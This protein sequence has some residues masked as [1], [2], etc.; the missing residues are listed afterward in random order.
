MTAGFTV[1]FVI[2]LADFWIEQSTFHRLEKTQ[3]LVGR[4][5]DA[6]IELL[7]LANAYVDAET[8]QR[9]Y[10]LTG[11]E[12]YL[13]PYVAA[14]SQLEK[15]A[16]GIRRV[17]TDDSELNAILQ[18]G[19]AKLAELART[20][21]LRRQ[22]R[23]DEALAIVRA[24]VGK[25]LMDQI[26][27]A[28]D[29][30][31]SRL[32]DTA[33]R[34]VA[35]MNR[36]RN[37]AGISAWVTK[38]VL[39]GALVMF[40]LVIRLI[41]KEREDALQAER[42]AKLATQQALASER[43]AHS[44]AAHANQL[45]DEFLG[46]VSHELRTPLSA[47]L[48]WT[49]LLREGAEDEDELQEGLAMIERNARAQSRLVEDLLDVSRIISGKVRL[50]IKEVNLR[51]VAEAV[52]EGLRPSAEAK[53]IRLEAEWTREPVEVL[54]DPDRLQQIG[55]NLVSNAIKFTPRNGRIWVRVARVD[56]CVEL[57]VEDTGRG[58]RPEFLPRIFDRFSQED[59]STTRQ[60]SGLGLGLA[61]A[62]HLVE[63]HGGTIS[64]ESAGEGCGTTFRVQI[65]IVAVREIRRQFDSRRPA[66][67]GPAARRERAPV[68]DVSGLRGLR[69]LA[70]DDQGDARAVY[71]RVLGRVG[72][73]VRTA[74]SVA[75]ALAILGEWK[76][77][78]IISDIGM[79]G[80][81]GYSFVRTLRSR[82]AN[83]GGNIPVLA[84]TAF[85]KP[86]DRRRALEAGFDSHLA[87]PVDV[88]ELTQRVAELTRSSARK[89]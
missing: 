56:S 74:E 86:E 30:L 36:Q 10:L 7:G 69:V 9:G 18:P 3:R 2:W 26:S 83:E 43:A 34:V 29:R 31:N 15:R 65:P 62:R 25:N 32:E 12:R 24:G 42:E 58:I 21:E 13:A 89:A 17:L 27:A 61:I 82:P 50:H 59:T 33:T 68:Q 57:S 60:N 84:L 75:A 54:G 79:P 41:W 71:A 47:I 63:L 80:E 5:K 72:A 85:A 39:G 11:D 81:D 45:K 40:Y 38:G 8:G 1:L 44:E 20:I 46:I 88:H 23:P 78:I 73:E 52:L 37:Q 70:V 76:P 64:A 48:G 87:K 66:I 51:R 6:R 14:R 67:D 35:S 28:A 19:E 55:W 22:G 4:L 77:E 16:A 53:G 49:T